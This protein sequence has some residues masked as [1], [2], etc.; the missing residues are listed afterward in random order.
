MKLNQDCNNKFNVLVTKRFCIAFSYSTCIGIFDK[1]LN[2]AYITS[3]KY[4]TTTGRHRNKFINDYLRE[5][6]TKK[7]V[8]ENYLTNF[9]GRLL[10][11]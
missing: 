3:E 7:Y 8:D 4:G 1:N 2:I 11:E 10:D 6:T 5:D 9:L